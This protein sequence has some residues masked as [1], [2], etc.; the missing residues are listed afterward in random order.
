MRP[1]TSNALLVLIGDILA[2]LL[3][4]VAL[5]HVTAVLGPSRFGAVTL[6]LAILSH[7]LLAVDL[8]LY[9]LGI[10]EAAKP[11]ESRLFPLGRFVRLE[12]MLATIVFVV[13]QGLLF[14]LP[15]EPLLEHV[16]RL[17]LFYTFSYALLVDWYHQGIRNYSAVTVSKFINGAVYAGGVYL[18]VQSE[19]DVLLV[20]IIYLA[21][22]LA[23]V[24]WLGLRIRR[25][26]FVS[27][28]GMVDGGFAAMLKGSVPI[29]AG[30]LLGQGIQALPP[31]V[32]AF[33]YSTVETGVFG[34]VLKIAT[35]LM[36]V[37]RIFVALFL[38]FV[39]RMWVERKE[40]LNEVLAA[41]LSLVVAASFSLSCVI[42]LCSRAILDLVAARYVSGAPALAVLAWYPAVTILNSY[43]AYSLIAIGREKSY[44]RVSLIS[45][46]FSAL[47]ILLFAWI[48]G[49]VG[50]AIA[51]VVGESFMTAVMYREFRESF[52]V[53]L[54][55]ALLP[56]LGV[57]IAI[58][59]LGTNAG[60]GLL[61][62]APVILLAFLAAV[63][64]LR[65]VTRRELSMI[66]GR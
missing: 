28:P 63:F 37:D 54:A 35:A 49:V 5:F 9:T 25:A 2:R 15:L 7:A 36:M 21:A 62:Q 3:G 39:S 56:S 52:R 16:L 22:N 60:I 48:W 27:A 18:L 64:L 31:I 17:Y 59:G 66:F 4:Y 19:G 65:G 23:S 13:G 38:P 45:A 43:F 14:V 40:R 12:L 30:A 34:I 44:L 61:W 55:R 50:A 11:P 41:A 33:Y 26:D 42:T 32:L 20:P 57:A 58:V 8:G 6:G 53:P 29:G 46:I 1:V 10:R 24:I 51:V 47:C